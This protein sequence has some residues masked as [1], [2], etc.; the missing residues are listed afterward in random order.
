MKNNDDIPTTDT[1]EIKRLINRVKQGELAGYPTTGGN[2]ALKGYNPKRHAVVVKRVVT[3]G[4]IPFCLP[5]PP[6][7]T[8]IDGLMRQVS[9]H[10][11]SFGAVHNPYDQTRIPGGSS[12]GSG[13]ILAARIV[14]AA[15]GLD[16]N[17]SVRC[18]SAFCGVTGFRPSTYMIENAI[19]GTSRKRYSDEGLVIPPARRLD[20]IGPMARTV[21][22]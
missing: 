9:S 4:G 22:G 7:M 13:A 10:S 19:K 12:G 14:P 3:A 5:S 15:L 2:G 6:D 16:T 8:V 17:G 21:S 20:T 1:N 18:P 11:K